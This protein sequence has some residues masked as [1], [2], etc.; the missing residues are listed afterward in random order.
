MNT[1][2]KKCGHKHSFVFALQTR[3]CSLE[4]INMDRIYLDH[5]AGT[6]V[7]PRVG[8]AME[9]FWSTTFGNPSS[10]HQEGVLARRALT[11]A[12][13]G[14]A[15]IVGMHSDEMIFTGSA[16]ES[17]NLALIGAV[18]AWKKTHPGLVP[19]LMVSAIEHDAVLSVARMLESEGALLTIVPVSAEGLI[20][21]SRLVGAITKNTVIIS[22]MYANNEIG[23]IE[24]I[25]DIAH[26][27]RKWKKKVRET[28]RDVRESPEDAYPLFHTDAT[29]AANYLDIH[30][31]KL[32]VDL[33]SFNAAKIYG[34]KGVGVLVARRG[35]MLTP[36]ILGGGQEAGL[37]AGTENVPGIV[38]LAEA[39]TLAREI[40]SEET[41]RLTKLR[42]L[43]IS[44]LSAIE[45]I[46]ING[47]RTERLPNNIHFSLAG[48]DHEFLALAFDARGIAVAT[49]S[50]CNETE[51]ETSHVLAALCEGRSQGEQ[52][53]I[54]VSLGRKTTAADIE[55]L[56]ETLL[57][58]KNTMI[59][60]G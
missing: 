28:R 32:G 46:T 34:P 7:D 20:D 60:T 40:A 11:S 3:E 22:I 25:R 55:R 23:T 41:A 39:L 53:G 18:N 56:I 13:A 42:D 4:C 52:G 8:S 44:K 35:A 19:H 51:A 14:I 57:D 26:E 54:R 5:A 49:K 50:A 30:M 21:V 43:A 10:I 16:T 15:S 6:P 38:G 48:A 47:S 1:L 12:R 27:I 59:V 33:M 24:P 2:C 31:P 29:Q 36:F 9:P 58:I 37:R 45:G 17:C